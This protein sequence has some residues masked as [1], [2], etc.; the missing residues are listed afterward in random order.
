MAIGSF[1]VLS[2]IAF[3]LFVKWPTTFMP[4][5]DDGYFVVSVQL[6]AASSLERTEAVGRQIDAILKQYPEIKT[7]L[8][9]IIKT[10][11]CYI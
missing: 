1:V 8:G 9:N 4:E 6:P 3:L 7:F 2:V 10:A 5:E 11:V